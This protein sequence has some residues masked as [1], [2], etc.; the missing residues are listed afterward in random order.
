MDLGNFLVGSDNLLNVK[1]SSVDNNLNL[2]FDSKLGNMSDDTSDMDN[3][4]SELS[5]VNLS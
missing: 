3:L 4:N 2:Q 5:V 1:G